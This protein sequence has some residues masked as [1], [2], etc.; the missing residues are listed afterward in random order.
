[1]NPMIDEVARAQKLRECDV[2]KLQTEPKGG[3]DVR[4]RWHCSRCWI[5]A[6]QRGYK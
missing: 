3:I 2:C 5:K 1:M 4:Q 6:M